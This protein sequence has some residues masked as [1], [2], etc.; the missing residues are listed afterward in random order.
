MYY[1]TSSYIFILVIR[2]KQMVETDKN[3]TVVIHYK[4]IRK[5]KFQ[6]LI[7]VFNLLLQFRG[8]HHPFAKCD[9]CLMFTW[10][11]IR[12]F[13]IVV[14]HHSLYLWRFLE[15]IRIL[16]LFLHWVYLRDSTLF[17]ISLKTPWNWSP[18]RPTREHCPF[19]TL[20]A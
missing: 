17:K 9:K 14:K 1:L 2:K 10:T 5:F 6:F 18:P 8:K 11:F 20:F 4:I 16:Y 3:F 7:L 15:L 13:R 12:L 19:C